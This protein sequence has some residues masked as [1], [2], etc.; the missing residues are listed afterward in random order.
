MAM[1]L[2]NF[3]KIFRA[4]SGKTF[5]FSCL[6][7]LIPA[8]HQ[9]NADTPI[10]NTVLK[11]IE[12]LYDR[13]LGEAESL[14]G[15]LIK[16][17][18]SDPTGYFYLAMVSWSRLASGFWTKEV[19]GEYG[20][21]IDKA[22]S[23]AEK[24]IRWD[25]P[26][27]FDYFYL[28]GALGYK[29]RF[30]L[31][32]KKYL[33]SFLLAIQAIDAL[34]TS[35]EMDPG[36]KDILLG[37]GLFDY[38]TARFKGVLKFLTYLFVNRSSKEEGLRKLH[39]AANSALY[40]SIE[41]KSMLLHIYLFLEDKSHDKALLIAKEL[42]RRFRNNPRFRFLEGVAYIRLG[43]NSKYRET[44]DFLRREPFIRASSREKMIWENRSLYL[45]ASYHLFQGR[46]G[47][48]AAKLNK[49]LS[50]ADPLF[51]PTMVAWPI[52]KLGMISDLEG[53]RREALE[54]YRKVMKLGN[55]AG[56]QFLAEKYTDEPVEKGDPFLVY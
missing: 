50:Q 40:S 8:G 23:V 28:G 9:T 26:D 54:Y 41:A 6:L 21:R 1:L 49:I 19:V 45:E 42:A 34:K 38:Y 2:N 4:L 18:P 20:R 30:E 3:L 16:Q 39:E 33:S 12:S 17:G 29:A 27:S 52:L 7:L 10:N 15:T 47:E 36:N 32:K 11:G 55:G 53:R 56:A 13:K 46:H 25:R 22:I 31:M 48:A 5:I 14:F 37:L 51:D 44:V 35:S 24:S 43:M